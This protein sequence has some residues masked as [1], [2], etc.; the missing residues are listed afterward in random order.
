MKALRAFFRFIRGVFRN[1]KPEFDE[2]PWRISN[3]PTSWVNTTT[4]DDK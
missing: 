1:R 2:V 3:P 4:G